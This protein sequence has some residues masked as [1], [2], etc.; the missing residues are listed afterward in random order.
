MGDHPRQEGVSMIDLLLAL[1]LV[2]AVYLVYAIIF[3]ERF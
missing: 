3:P 2:I 1:V